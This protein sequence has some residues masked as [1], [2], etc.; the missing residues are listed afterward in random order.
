MSAISVPSEPF[1]GETASAGARLAGLGSLVATSLLKPVSPYSAAA[2]RVVF[3]LLGLAAVVRFAVNGW[4]SQLYVEPVHHFSYYGFGWV[5]PWPGWG[6][7]LHFALLAL[8]SLG[9]ALGYRYRLSIIAFFLL[10]TYV[11]LI[12]RT[13]YLNHYY[14]VSVLSFVM[15]FLP[16]QRVA[17]FDAGRRA[18]CEDVPAIPRGVLWLL[19][20]QIGLVY[21]FAGIAK[22]NPDWLFH[23]QPLR[24]WLYNAADVPLIGSFLREEWVAYAVSWGGVV[25]D[26]TIVGWLLWRKSR[27]LAYGLL[28]TFHV[29]TAL[30]FPALG[31]FPWIMIAI[32]LIFF[33]PNW[34][35][36]L[37]RR[38]RQSTGRRNATAECRQRP[39]VRHHRNWKT[40][41][42]IAAAAVFLIVQVAVPL[43]HF[44]YPGNVRWTEEGY[45]FA[46]RMMLTEK[47]GQVFF[48]VSETSETKERLVYPDEYLMPGQIERMS[49]QPDLILATA[50]LIRDDYV[51][52]GYDR[53]QVRADAYVSYN[54]RPAARL[55]DPDVN[56]ST[57]SP[58]LGYRA[59][60]MPEPE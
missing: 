33:A 1:P 43:R 19:M 49:H 53:V 13:T 18:A 36:N 7:Y 52:Q 48:R 32:T 30:L 8:A 22:L 15:I 57:I 44:A 5:Q 59:W 29:T 25:F 27:P 10:F 41:V 24:I 51:E 3:G 45:L 37:L 21:V 4:I 55:I 46:W 28:V 34:P 20:A 11:Q 47:A 14:L 54:G 40:A 16:L 56:L 2:F 39:P 23:A 26:L 42:A 12:D 38:V 17:S 31:M 6:M 58:G 50:H 35:L 9:V 60:V